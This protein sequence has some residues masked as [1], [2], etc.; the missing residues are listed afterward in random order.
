M[1]TLPLAAALLAGCATLAAQPPEPPEPPHVE[2]APDRVRVFRY[3][4]PADGRRSA[5]GVLLGEADASGLRIA[6]V[7]P[8]G[9]AA[10]AGIAAGDQ[11][12]AVNGASLRLD[13]ADEDD[14]LLAAV[15]ARRLER[16][17]GR[18]A[19]GSEVEL[20]YVRDGRERTVRLRTVAPTTLAG[21]GR[22]LDF[23]GPVAPGDDS[24]FD[25]PRRRARIAVDSPRRSAAARP[26]L[27][28]TLGGTGSARDTLGLFVSA[29]A[30]GGPAERAGVVEGDRVA[31]FDGVD[32]RVPREERDTPEAAEARR[33]RFT[34]ELGRL[35]P[36]DQVTLHLWSDGRWRTVTAT[37]GRSG[38]VYQGPAALGFGGPVLEGDV[39]RFAPPGAL[40]PGGLRELRAFPAPGRVRI[41][42]PPMPPVAPFRW[43][44][45]GDAPMERRVPRPVRAPRRIVDL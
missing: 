5:I 1:R 37:V 19:P 16:T 43:R 39:L 32:V 6:R 20:R 12:V 28:L 38:D 22:R 17:V 45:E 18:L 7:T 11:L 8:D 2:R 26:V 40:P 25:G 44:M 23:F 27:G 3:A 4:Q 10:R 14:P 29:V 34:R 13:R 42:R 31:A 41:P 9:P 21:V 24:G 30:P 35:R 36:G 15:P 33:A